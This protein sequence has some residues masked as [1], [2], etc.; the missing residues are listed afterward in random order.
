MI[1]N[2]NRALSYL[3]HGLSVIPVWSPEMLKSYQPKSYIAK[4]NKSLAENKTSSNSLP[5]VSK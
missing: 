2:L 3:K 5:E 1:N 4:V